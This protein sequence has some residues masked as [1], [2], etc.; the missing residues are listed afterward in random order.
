MTKTL[1]ELYIWMSRAHFEYPLDEI[2]AAAFAAQ[3]KELLPQ[4]KADALDAARWRA[5]LG[6]ERIKMQGSAG[7]T[8]D[9]DPNGKPYNGYAH[10]GMEIW[11]QFS[12]EGCSQ[13]L[14]DDIVQ[15]NATGIEMLTKYADIALEQK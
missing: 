11:T 8:S 5:L 7:L 1:T 12:K 14:Q 13:K 6:S 3:I 9:T 2:R 4:L 10:F 15:G